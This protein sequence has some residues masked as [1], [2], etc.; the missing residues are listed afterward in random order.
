MGETGYVRELNSIPWREEPPEG[1]STVVSTFSGCGGSSLGYRMA[2]FREM[3]AIDFDE[4]AVETFARNF[5]GVPVWRR[6]ITQVSAD[7]VLSFCGIGPGDL[8]VL[9]G[10]PPCFPAGS[11]V[12]V[13]GGDVAIESVGEGMHVLTHMGRYRRV[14]GRTKRVADVEMRTIRVKY[15][16][17]PIVCT[18]D[19][20]IFSMRWGA[21]GGLKS[22]STPE[23][24]EARSLIPG[25][26]V[27]EPHIAEADDLRVPDVVTKQRINLEGQSGTNGFEMRLLVRPCALDWKTPEMAWV[28]GFYTAEGHTR[29]HN[30]IL[31][32]VGPCRRE[33]IFS[34]AD[35]EAVGLVGRLARLGFMSFVQKHSQGA[36]RVSVS[37]LDLWALVRVM[38]KGAAGKRVPAA[39]HIQ[40]D[41]WQRAFLDGY[42][43]GDGCYKRNGKGGVVRKATTVSW[44]LATGVA[45][46]VARAFGV[47]ASIDVLYPS[48]MGEIQG[49]RVSFREAY[50]VGYCLPG[51]GRVRPGF[52]DGMGAWL[53]VVENGAE[54][55]EG[56]EVYNLEVEEDQSYVVGG[57]AVHNCQGFSTVGKRRVDDPRNSLF[58]DFVRMIG[59][60]RPRVFLMENVVGQVSG[61]MRGAFIEIMEA[62]KGTGYKVRCAMLDAAN[63]GV[64][65]HRKRLI[66]VGVRPD[67][68]AGPSFPR[69]SAGLV[70][71]GEAIGDMEGMVDDPPPPLLPWRGKSDR[72]SRVIGQ[73]REGMCG[74]S[75]DGRGGFFGTSRLDRAR[76]SCTIIKTLG[77]IGVIHYG[78]VRRISIAELKRL[79]SFP[80]DFDLV[81]TYESRWARIGNSVMPL[82]MRALA[83][84]IRKEI[85]GR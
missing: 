37:D 58:K 72:W 84:H 36:S 49:R 28:L 24:V 42:F 80:D 43:E 57:V 51:S 20:P 75:V 2:G 19:H 18:G 25:D 82:F 8:D 45:K 85:L 40:P 30:P 29:G 41:D 32:D 11:K 15:G 59:G 54:R 50:S 64:P 16:R 65:Q 79:C 62:L 68:A 33:V 35:K 77:P 14:V 56:A 10:S 39:F 38:G 61:K 1:S 53:P 22:Y 17:R 4:N 76:P 55:V 69:P 78:S 47:V 27:L 12:S 48:G 66:Y 46:M 31:D 70:T 73:I 5:P 67:V 9:D 34:V 3:L 21:G 63:F 26:V 74:S 13:A 83:S 44:E 60:T 81:G 6:D 23:W 52:V 7:E 71:C